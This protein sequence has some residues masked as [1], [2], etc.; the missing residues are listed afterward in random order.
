MSWGRKKFKP[1]SLSCCSERPC[2]ER[3]SWRIGTLEALQL[4]ING[5]K[6]LGGNCRRAV[7]EMAVTCALA[8]SRLAFGCR[9][10]VTI[11]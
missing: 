2:P 1:R 8:V 10:I 3:V 7:W 9:K 4:M 5:G 11:A 6:V